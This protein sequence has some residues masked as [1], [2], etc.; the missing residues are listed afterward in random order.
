MVAMHVLQTMV[1]FVLME[2]H[3]LYGNHVALH[4]TAYMTLHMP[5]H[6]KLHMTLHAAR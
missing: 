2:V 1:I 5:L 3:V 6:K 4:S